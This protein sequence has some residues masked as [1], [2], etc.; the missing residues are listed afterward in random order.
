MHDVD[1]D[2]KESKGVIA[3]VRRENEVDCLD[4]FGDDRCSREASF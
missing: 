4:S 3:S 2:S 1:N